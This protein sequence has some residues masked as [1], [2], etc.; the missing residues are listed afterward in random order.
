VVSGPLVD[1]ESWLQPAAED[2]RATPSATEDLE[3]W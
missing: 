3:G 1:V 2:L